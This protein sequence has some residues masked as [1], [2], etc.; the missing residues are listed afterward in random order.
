MKKLIKLIKEGKINIGEILK[1]PLILKSYKWEDVEAYGEEV[2]ERT[3]KTEKELEE[4]LTEAWEKTLTDDS[5]YMMFIKALKNMDLE[6]IRQLEDNPHISDIKDRFYIISII[7]KMIDVNFVSVFKDL[8]KRW[9]LNEEEKKEIVDYTK[10]KKGE[11]EASKVDQI[12][13]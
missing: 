13:K 3:Q 9:N 5:K 12:L 2:L 10:K 11:E 7:K 8:I 4:T 1:N 6:R